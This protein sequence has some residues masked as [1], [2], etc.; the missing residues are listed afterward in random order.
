MK[1]IVRRLC[2][3]TGEARQFLG[4]TTSASNLRTASSQPCS[5]LGQMLSRARVHALMMSVGRR[6]VCCVA[7][8]G[9]MSMSSLTTTRRKTASGG[10]ND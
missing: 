2:S 1:C 8:A 10:V 5:A 9:T 3:K 4:S 6:V 7:L